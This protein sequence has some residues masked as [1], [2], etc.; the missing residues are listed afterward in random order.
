MRMERVEV[1]LREDDFAEHLRT[2]A[3]FLRVLAV[4]ICHAVSCLLVLL[5][6]GVLGHWYIGFFWLALASAAAVAGIMSPAVGAKA[7]V[8]VLVLTLATFVLCS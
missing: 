1:A 3:F 7:S 8:A 6:G 2:Y 5:I 4:A